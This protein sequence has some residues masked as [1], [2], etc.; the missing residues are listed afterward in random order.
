M[1]GDIILYPYKKYKAGWSI[2]S[3][4]EESNPLQMVPAIKTTIQR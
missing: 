3:A 4:T 1:G 2:P